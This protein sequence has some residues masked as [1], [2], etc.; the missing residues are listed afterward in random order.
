MNLLLL[1]GQ[2]RTNNAMRL[3]GARLR[4]LGHHVGYFGY[5]TRSDEKFYEIAQRLIVTIK[6]M[7][8]DEPYALVGHS[9]GGLLSRASLPALEDHPPFHLFLLASPSRPPRLASRAA[10]SRLYR[11]IT[12]DCG[13][14]VARA[15]FYQNLPMPTV[16]T[17][18]IAGTGGPQSRWLPYGYEANDMAMS[19]D[20]TRLGPDHEVIQVPSI[21]TFIMNS[22]H[23]FQ[24]IARVLQN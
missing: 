21:H 9:M 19:V 20:E 17:T 4:R 24:H 2:G 5:N 18:I 10:R 13:Q 12:N 1:H 23:T 8:A 15:E 3:L 6:S 14:Q 7:P 16:P 11:R 22:H